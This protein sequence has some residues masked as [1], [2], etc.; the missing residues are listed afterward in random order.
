MAAKC[1]HNMTESPVIYFNLRLISF[2]VPD[3]LDCVL[4][5]FTEMWSITKCGPSCNK[6]ENVNGLS[7]IEFIGQFVCVLLS[8]NRHVRQFIWH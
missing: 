1:P 5:L 2:Q 4:F 8:Y 6:I 7:T 3:G